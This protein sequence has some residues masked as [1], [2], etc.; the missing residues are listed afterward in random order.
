[1]PDYMYYMYWRGGAASQLFWQ[2]PAADL[3]WEQWQQTRLGA[4]GWVCSRLAPSPP[5]HAQGPNSAQELRPR[6][7]EAGC[8]VK[9]ALSHR[10]RARSSAW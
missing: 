7:G 6:S 1:M 8:W 2:S 3:R 9:Q 10:R 5:R 4:Q